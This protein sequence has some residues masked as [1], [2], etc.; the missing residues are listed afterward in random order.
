M[1][2]PQSTYIV[3]V[4]GGVDSM[5]L[6]HWLSNNYPDT[7]FVVA[8]VNHGIRSDAFKDENLVMETAQRYGYVFEVENYNLG[9]DA[10]E[11]LA[12][13]KRYQFLKKI[14]QKHQAV[15]IITAH[16][17]DDVLETMVINMVRGTGR[18]G[19]SSLKTT[20]GIVRPFIDKPKAEIYEYADNNHIEWREDST[21]QDTKYLRNK[22]RH[23]VIKNMDDSQKN[24]LININKNIQNINFK[25]DKDI[26]SLTRRGLH[27][28]APV[29]NRN[30]FIMLPHDVS[31]EVIRHLLEENGSTNIDKK[32]IERVTIYIKTK[33]AGKTIEVSGLTIELTKR[34]AR[35]K[36]HRKTE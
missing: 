9:E 8:H 24:I 23:Q 27:K 16:H 22:I 3:A 4:S 20:D 26:K 30:W 36:K 14:A 11:S 12:R 17:Q 6:L 28:G 35:F 18:R 2:S 34:S 1:I 32:T 31:T 29:L 21:N 7:N 13:E 33:P 5:A 15:A 25:I 10:S 19:L